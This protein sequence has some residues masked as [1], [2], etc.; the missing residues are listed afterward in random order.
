MGQIQRIQSIY[1]LIAAIASSAL[2][3][4][5]FATAPIQQ[6]GMFVDGDFDINDHI[7]LI[8]LTTVVTILSFVTVFLYNN[9]ILQINI[10]KVNVILVLILIGLVG[11]LFS[12]FSIVPSLGVG[13]IIPIV[14][15]IFILL[16]NKNIKKDEKLVRSA[17]RLR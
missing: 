4:L 12:T 6:E 14:V 15:F 13:L 3:V 5:P 8:V 2:F 11:Y 17:D 10:G 16:A 1:L 9:R 7:A